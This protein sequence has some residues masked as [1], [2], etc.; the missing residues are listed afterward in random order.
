MNKQGK[1]NRHLAVLR[2]I[3]P[4]I[5]SLEQR[6]MLDATYDAGESIWTITPDDPSQS[7]VIEIKSAPN[8]QIAATVNGTV[9]GTIS[10]DDVSDGWIEVHG[11]SGDDKITVKL[12]KDSNI[13]VDLYG[14]DGNDTLIG[15]SGN[16]YLFGEGGDDS[17]VGGA[18]DDNLDGG[19]GNDYSLNDGSDTLDGGD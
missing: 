3:N 16:D 19:D 1:E 7:V 17:L 8:N 2:A 5:E 6:R 12:G 15:G 9:V 4:V 13:E 14:G 11:G 10:A 18:G